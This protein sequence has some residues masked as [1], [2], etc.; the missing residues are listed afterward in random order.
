MFRVRKENEISPDEKDPFF[1]FDGTKRWTI[2]NNHTNRTLFSQ[3]NGLRKA[4]VLDTTKKLRVQW[5]RTT[6]VSPWRFRKQVY[7]SNDL[8][9]FLSSHLHCVC[10]RPRYARAFPSVSL[11][12]WHPPNIMSNE[13][14]T[15]FPRDLSGGSVELTAH[16]S[17][18]YLVSRQEDGQRDLSAN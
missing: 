8:R 15:L 17:T 2:N 14:R 11:L 3:Q 12:N 13:D 9:S 10:D 6:S 4:T 1:F 5:W 18:V 7:I 16:S